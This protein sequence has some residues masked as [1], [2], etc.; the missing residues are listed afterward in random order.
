MTLLADL[1]D[2]ITRHRACHRFVSEV[3]RPTP[4][5]GTGLTVACRCGVT[6][7][8]WV[9]PQDA[10]EELLAEALQPRA[11]RNVEAP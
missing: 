4:A 3:G 7:E 5:R 2:F 8:R 11:G 10:A 6:F 1:E 9:L